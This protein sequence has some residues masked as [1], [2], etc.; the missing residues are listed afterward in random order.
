MRNL[1]G[2]LLLLPFLMVGLR[3]QI[4]YQIKY[5]HND[6]KTVTSFRATSTQEDT[7]YYMPPP[8]FHRGY[9]ESQGWV[10]GLFDADASTSEV[11]KLGFQ[12]F[13]APKTGPDPSKNIGVEVTYSLFGTG[14]GGQSRIWLLTVG[15]GN[16]PQNPITLP[17]Q[18]GLRL[19]LPR[20]APGNGQ[21][22]QQVAL[23]VLQQQGNKIQYP[24]G[25]SRT[26][27]TFV[28]TGATTAQSIGQTGSTFF[29][30]SL[31]S[32]PTLQIYLSSTAYGANA[33]DLF[34]PEALY[35]DAAR[36]DKIGWFLSYRKFG[37]RAGTQV[38][39]PL[40]APATLGTNVPTPFGDLILGLNFLALPPMTLN[41]TGT[42]D[43]G[44]VS[45]PKGITLWTQALFV[46][47]FKSEMR[48]SCAQ[49]IRSQ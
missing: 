32:E 25:V 12:A 27:M 43:S 38:V 9:G 18:Y 45:I 26:Q 3:A 11:V 8:G 30:G 40:V 39:V 29:F 13:D 44:P 4:T 35:P 5:L 36:G 2:L 47:L 17:D 46:D 24:S 22:W 42:A 14:T 31:L 10:V 15:A 23:S 20:P 7:L 21:T 33:E 6:Q 49:E 16:P 1:L 37:F 34:G 19:T 41:A 28:K 48:L